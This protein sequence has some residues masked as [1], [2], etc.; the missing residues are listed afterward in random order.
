MKELVLVSH[1]PARTDDEIDGL[2]ELAR[3][4]FPNTRAAFEGM[5]IEL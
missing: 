1:D 3:A 4:V 2:V 5:Q